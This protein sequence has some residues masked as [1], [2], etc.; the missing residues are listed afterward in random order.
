L[1]F[2]EFLTF[3]DKQSLVRILSDEQTVLLTKKLM[4][5][6][7]EYIRYG[8]YPECILLDSFDEKERYLKEIIRTYIKKDIVD[9]G[10]EKERKF[11]FLLKILASQIGQF[12]N[13]NELSNTLD[14][15]TTTI[16]KY[17]YVM[18]KSYHIILVHPFF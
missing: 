5:Y 16:S 12:L 9:G 17:I 8:G 13:I 6:Y 15:S 3:K 18:E 4:L 11:L 7:Y 10:V 14:L 1:T 2:E